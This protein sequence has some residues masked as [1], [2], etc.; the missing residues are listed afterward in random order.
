MFSCRKAVELGD[1]FVTSRQIIKLFE[2]RG[3]KG[4]NIFICSLYEIGNEKRTFAII[5][6]D[7]SLHIAVNE[8][9]GLP[10]KRYTH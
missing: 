2:G 8:R 10:S 3:T 7:E 4:V 5:L 1:L 6:T 9:Q